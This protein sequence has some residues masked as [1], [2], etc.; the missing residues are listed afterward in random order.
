MI[1]KMRKKKDRENRKKDRKKERMK[2]MK[3]K[4]ERTIKPTNYIIKTFVIF[5]LCE[6]I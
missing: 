5:V 1:N 6:D 2:E 4:K 3:G